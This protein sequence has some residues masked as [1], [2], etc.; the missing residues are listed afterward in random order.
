LSGSKET[1]LHDRLRHG[2][3]GS[4]AGYNL[5]VSDSGFLQQTIA[6]SDS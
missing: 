6:V 3:N 5:R 1:D 4:T 2:P